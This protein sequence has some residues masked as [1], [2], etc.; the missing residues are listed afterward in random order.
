MCVLDY[1]LN[2]YDVYGYQLYIDHFS[3]SF[4]LRL[5]RN[6]LRLNRLRARGHTAS[7]KTSEQCLC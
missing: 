3:H 4:C 7:A 1:F 2:T 5:R 6:L